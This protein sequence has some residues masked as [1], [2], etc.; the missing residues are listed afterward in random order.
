MIYKV[1]GDTIV[2]RLEKG[3]EIISAITE[4]CKEKAISAGSVSAIGAVDNVILGLYKVKE[5]KRYSREHLL[6]LIFKYYSSEY[7]EEMEMTSLTGNISV[8]DNEPYLHFHANFGRED[9]SVV[10]G[11]LNKAVISATCEIIIHRIN[12]VIGRK[13]D[14]EIGLNVIEFN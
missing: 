11:H 3:E 7:K 14:D 2:M 13:F 12:G 9:G 6:L 8:K 5:K 1:F 10:G 4:L